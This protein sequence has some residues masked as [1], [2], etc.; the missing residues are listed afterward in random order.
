MKNLNN[1]EI[2]VATIHNSHI[3]RTTNKK[4]PCNSNLKCVKATW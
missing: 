4:A 2:E 3:S 1:Y